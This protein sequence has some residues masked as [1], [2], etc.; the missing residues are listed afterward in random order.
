MERGLR[1]AVSA[2]SQAPS[3]AA[4]GPPLPARS[5]HLTP[6][7]LND[8]SKCK[9]AELSEFYYIFNLCVC[10]CVAVILWGVRT[11]GIVSSPFLV[12]WSGLASDLHPSY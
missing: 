12:T 1:T 5:S 9:F 10:V 11:T 6:A 2:Q 4:A 8:V 7:A 3:P